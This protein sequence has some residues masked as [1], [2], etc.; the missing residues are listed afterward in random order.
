MPQSGSAAGSS[1]TP[2][3]LSS[4]SGVG[5]GERRRKGFFKANAVNEEFSGV[6]DEAALTTNQRE[7]P[8]PIHASLLLI[9]LVSTWPT[10]T[11]PAGIWYGPQEKDE[12]EG[13]HGNSESGY[14]KACWLGF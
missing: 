8:L 5:G 11:G 6:G 12:R 2:C 10:N 4:L 14:R 7:T 9:F 1:H 13:E 3:L